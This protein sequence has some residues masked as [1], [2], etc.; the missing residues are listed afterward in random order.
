MS[1]GEFGGYITVGFDH[2]I[3]NT[4]GAD[5]A[6]K[7]NAFENWSEP[8]VVWVMQDENGNGLPDETWYELRGSETGKETTE[9]NFYVTYMKPTGSRQDVAWIDANGNTGT[10]DINGYHSQDSFYPNWVDAASYTLYGTY[11]PSQME[12]QSGNGTYYVNPE[13]EWGYVDNMGSDYIGAETQLD[14]DNAM[15]PDGTSIQLEHVDF[16][17]IQVAQN[18]KGGWLGEI[19]TEVSGV[20]DMNMNE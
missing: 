14:I 5:I 15:Y 8:A 11:L 7:G 19:S 10:V 17:K 6:I 1:L 13:F 20:R 4:A 16:V 18:G 2:S 9:Q 12:D 3:E